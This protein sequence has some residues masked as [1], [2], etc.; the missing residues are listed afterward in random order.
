[1]PQVEL[2]PGQLSGK[3]CVLATILSSC[4]EYQHGQEPTRLLRRISWRRAQIV[5][6]TTSGVLDGWLI[7]GLWGSW[8]LE[9]RIWQ[10]SK[11]EGEW[12]RSFEVKTSNEWGDAASEAI[13]GRLEEFAFG[14]ESLDK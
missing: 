4:A 11:A 13:I 7:A 14:D 12:Q 3:K 2:I 9:E 6:E 1:M 10:D 5:K 8:K